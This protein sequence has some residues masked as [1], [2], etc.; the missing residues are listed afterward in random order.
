MPHHFF[1]F[2]YLHIRTL[3]FGLDNNNKKILNLNIFF[4]QFLRMFFMIM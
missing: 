3:K 1:L 2:T 4:I